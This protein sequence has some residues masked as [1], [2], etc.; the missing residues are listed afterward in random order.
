MK[1]AKTLAIG[2]LSGLLLTACG[3]NGGEG[4]NKAQEPKQEQK[5]FTSM[6]ELKKLDFEN[7]DKN[8]WEKIYLS[9][10]TFQTFLK[11]MKSADDQGTVNYKDAQLK[12]SKTIELTANNSDGGSLE[13][14]M[15]AAVMDAYLREVYKHSELFDDKKEPT[16]TTVDLNGTEIASNNQ[17]NKLN[18]A[19]SAEE[20]P[21]DLG[22]SKMGQQ[23][24]IE[25][26][27]ITLTNARYTNER[28][29]FADTKPAKVLLFD[30]EYQNATKEE[31]T[32]DAGSF[33][34]YDSKG[35]KMEV[36]PVE[37]LTETIQPGKHV[38][39]RAAFGVTGNAPYQVYYTDYLTSTKATWVME[40]K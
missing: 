22:T 30:V 15:Q 29:E 27:M 7:P 25:G 28:N 36:Y 19:A 4:A 23:V 1:F 5:K 20:K 37:Y 8:Q 12:D 33:E 6:E 40:V 2:L 31:Q 17:P 9:K 32:I 18:E 3:N 24:N 11:A 26:N 35:E 39:G 21:K 16:I 34:V 38:K 13:N 10:D 14:T